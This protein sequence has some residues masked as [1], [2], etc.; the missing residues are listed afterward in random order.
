M[1]NDK[2]RPPSARPEARRA[3]R[4]ANLDT[5]RRKDRE[6]YHANPALVLWSKA[7]QRARLKGLEFSIALTDIHIP[8]RCPV[9]GTLLTTGTRANHNDAPTLDRIDPKKGYTPDNIVVMSWRA[10][11]IKSDAT[12][13]EIAKL[14]AFLVNLAAVP[15]V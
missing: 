5:L 8:E 6:R 14:A 2:P 15:P 13:D 9:F 12:A 1:V 7:K 11:K 4:R 10:N 3:Y